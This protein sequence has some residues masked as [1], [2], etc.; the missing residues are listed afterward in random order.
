MYEKSL[1][2]TENSGNWTLL[3]GPVVSQRRYVDRS[4]TC[5]VPTSTREGSHA[6]FVSVTMSA[7]SAAGCEVA[8]GCLDNVVLIQLSSQVKDAGRVLRVLVLN[9][10]SCQSHPP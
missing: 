1:K 3:N 4:S 10:C 5:S 7:S 8:A 2:S 9:P 6:A